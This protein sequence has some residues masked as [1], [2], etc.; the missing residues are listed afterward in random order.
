M[1]INKNELVRLLKVCLDHTGFP[2]P[3]PIGRFF[4]FHSRGD[5]SFSLIDEGV[6]AYYTIVGELLAERQIGDIYSK[7]AVEEKLDIVLMDLL[8]LEQLPLAQ[9]ALRA[10]VDKLLTM[11][12][13]DLPETRY[14]LG[15][16]NLRMEDELELGPVTIYPLTQEKDQ[17]LVQRMDSILDANPHYSDAKKTSWKRDLRNFLE[18]WKGHALAETT[19]RAD[20]QRGV[21]LSRRFL[22]EAL[23][24]LRFLG[25]FVYGEKDDAWIGEM[26]DIHGGMRQVLALAEGEFAWYL[27]RT[28]PMR[29]FELTR[30]IRA[31]LESLGLLELQDILATY[32][33]QRTELQKALL[34][35]V[36]WI[37]R[38]QSD[39]SPEGQLVKS[40]I[41]MESILLKRRERQK[42]ETMAGRLASL[43]PES[44]E[45][46]ERIFKTSK[47]IYEI[48]NAIVHEGFSTRTEAYIPI[49][50]QYAL[51][52]TSLLLA[53][54]QMR[55]WSTVEDVTNW[56]DL[57]ASG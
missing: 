50:R 22:E 54:Y 26:G 32:M 3:G 43:L 7:K 2:L 9:A 17:A 39:D 5:R 42:K 44:P 12:E 36:V 10:S 46:R 40:C 13:E 14:F 16:A 18:R 55:A 25:G 51:Q 4:L 15:I 45:G 52:S 1:P 38:A 48:R 47:D 23:H 27:A 37:S 31:K 8:K 21:E 49:A 20:K 11:F 35:A 57:K 53:R 56:L 33:A 41:A 34:N 28:G 19:S 30:K 29:P 6:T 24:V